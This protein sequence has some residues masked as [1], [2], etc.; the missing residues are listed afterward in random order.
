VAVL[1]E[2]AGRRR[3]FLGGEEAA[4]GAGHRKE[5]EDNADITR[6]KRSMRKMTDRSHDGVHSLSTKVLCLYI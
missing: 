5:E 3:G 1:L 6:K 2:A 4:G